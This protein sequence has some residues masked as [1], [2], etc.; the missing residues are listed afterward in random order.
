MYKD[1]NY[2]IKMIGSGK[3]YEADL[4]SDNMVEGDAR[5][6]ALNWVRNFGKTTKDKQRDSAEIRDGI[7]NKMET[8]DINEKL[9]LN[10]DLI[11][12]LKTIHTFEFD[13]FEFTDAC[14]NQE[15]FIVASYLM[16]KH[17]LF[18]SLKIYP[19]VF[20]T[21]I[22]TIQAGYK[23]VSYHNKTHATDV[24]Q[25]SYYYCIDCEFKDK[26]QLSDLDMC[27]IIV[28]TS[29]HDFEHFGV[30]N[31]YLTETKHELTLRYND[32]SVL[33]NHHVAASQKIMN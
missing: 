15:L 27:S 17:E 13:I 11:E 26:A 33:E 24:C 21:F 4:D 1:V 29:C 19:E 23:N 8:L 5:T 3:L 7:S 32:I 6:E 10:A 9:D 28:A 2:C 18:E 30:N 20:F 12:R 31:A 16:N 22:R 25:N 14:N